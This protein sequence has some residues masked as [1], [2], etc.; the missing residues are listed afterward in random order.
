MAPAAKAASARRAQCL[1][2]KRG[3]FALTFVSYVLFHASRKSFSAVKGEMSSEQWI[4]SRV[5]P[6]DQQAQMYGL[7]DTLFMAFYALGLYV[8]GVLGD[9]HDLRRMIAG[10]MW[11]TAAV[12]LV[13]G[14]GALADIHSLAFYA[15]LW[16][17]NGL[18]QST[19]W[20]ANVAVMCG[21]RG[22]RARSDTR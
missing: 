22:T 15:V 13:F 17:L 2:S 16:G 9:K 8:S 4:H 12:V 7:L 18:I 6:R 3:A 21:A 10:G 20:P 14:L 11:G 19:G 1:G 5:Y